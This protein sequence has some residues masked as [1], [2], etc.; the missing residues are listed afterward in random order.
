MCWNTHRSRFEHEP[1]WASEPAHTGDL[2]IA[3]TDRERAIAQLSK[4]AGDGRLTLEEFEARVEEVYAARTYAD[5]GHV[6]VG[7]P[8]YDLA[9]PVPRRRRPVD[10][11]AILRPVVMLAV[12]LGAAIAFGAWVLWIGLWFV[13]PRLMW[14]RGRH[15]HVRRT[16]YLDT[17]GRARDEELTNV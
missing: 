10:A 3:D 7:L 6:F 15:G 9:P 1:Q 17:S 12:L 5:L 8:R 11:P 4:H 16:D 14:G 13:V 2:R